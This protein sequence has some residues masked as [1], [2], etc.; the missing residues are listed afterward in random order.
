LILGSST[1]AP[2]ASDQQNNNQAKGSVLKVVVIFA[3]VIGGLAFLAA[4]GA[5]A[6]VFLRMRKKSKGE[7]DGKHGV[8]PPQ[9]RLYVSGLVPALST[10]FLTGV[11]RTRP[12]RPPSTVKVI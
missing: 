12:T 9:M 10:P 11:D 4:A 8:Q 6:W 2:T 7:T 5:G 1:S 3:G